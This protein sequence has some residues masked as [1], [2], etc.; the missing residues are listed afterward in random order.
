MSVTFV[1]ASSQALDMG[2]TLP[3]LNAKGGGTITAW[4]NAATTHGGGVCNISIGNASVTTNTRLGCGVRADG[5]V[6]VQTRNGT[7]AGT[8][9]TNISTTGYSTGTW[10][11]VAVTVDLPNDVTR[12]YIN[13]VEVNNFAVA[14]SISTWPA[15]DSRNGA[16]GAEDNAAAT[17]FNGSLADVRVYDRPLSAAEIMGQFVSRGADGIFH[18][19]MHRWNLNEL[20]PGTTATAPR[21]SAVQARTLTPVASPV[22]AAHP[23]RTRRASF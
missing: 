2:A 22:Y 9:V 13:G 18:G 17:F 5:F 19:C 7:D 11:H 15:T 16:V 6:Q 4:V 1:A 14:Y 10:F 21:D 3:A 12:I 8:L 23:I 20:S